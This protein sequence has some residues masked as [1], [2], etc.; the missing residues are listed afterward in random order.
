MIY[1]WFIDNVIIGDQPQIVYTQNVLQVISMP[2]R[3]QRFWTANVIQVIRMPERQQRCFT[4][5]RLIVMRL[6]PS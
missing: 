2:V 6:P 5:N 4:M 3:Q 1:I